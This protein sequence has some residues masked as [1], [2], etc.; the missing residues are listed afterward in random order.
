MPAADHAK[1][2][3]QLV[4]AK[5]F[6][7]VLAPF[8]RVLHGGIFDMSHGVVLIK[9]WGRLGAAFDEHVKLILH[10]LRDEGNYGSASDVVAAVIVDS[11][12]GACELYIEA[13]DSP[14]VTDEPLVSLG[15]HLQ[16]VVVVRGAHLAIV[17]QLPS[18]DH[19][20]IHLDALKWVVSKLTQFEDAKRKDDR[21]R[22]LSFFKALAHLLM[23]LDGKS[24]LKA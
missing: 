8:I 24:A 15:R 14:S 9:H 1:E 22:A 11:L 23:G 3:A 19:L 12:K 13:P 2:Q 17:H 10:D 5:R 4:A 20:R 21:N 18:E 7:Q 6:E 16:G